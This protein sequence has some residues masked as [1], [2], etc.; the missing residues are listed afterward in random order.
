MLILVV[1]GYVQLFEATS[2]VSEL[3]D[4]LLTLQ[5][6]Q[7]QLQS[8]YEARIDLDSI[9]TAAKDLGLSKPAQDQI[10]Y[11]NLAGTD[12]AEIYQEEKTSVIGEIVSAMEQSV[13]SLIAYLRAA[14]A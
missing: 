6:Q 11:V 4:Q 9:E 3:E 5:A 10:V 7:T 13:S 8:R 12:R 14:S 2:R 1:F